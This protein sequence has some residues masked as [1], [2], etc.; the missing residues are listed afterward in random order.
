MLLQILILILYTK[1]L[2]QICQAE[3]QETQF[4]NFCR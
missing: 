3:Q 1:Q 2:Q 4:E